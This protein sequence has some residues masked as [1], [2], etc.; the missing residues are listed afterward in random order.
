[1]AIKDG[2]LAEFDHEMAAT[3][4]LLDRIPD[5]KLAWK[6]HDKSYSMGG[7][8][9]HLA[10][11]PNWTATILEQL[12]FD[13]ADAP[14]RPADRTSRSEILGLFDS[15][16]AAARKIMD[17]SDA[18]YTAP[19]S[20]KRGNQE[21]FTIPRVAAFRSWVLSHSIHHRG[22]LSVYLRLNDLPVPA[23][24]GPSADEG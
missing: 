1:M 4:K 7:L 2:L 3:R 16:V 24:Y 15:T 8:A 20:L 19:W 13:M 12:S 6:P 9:T 14:P 5:E 17:K 10:S 11:L 18:E 22:Q 21:L 23:I